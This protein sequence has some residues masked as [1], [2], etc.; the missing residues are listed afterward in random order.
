MRI[1]IKNIE[2]SNFLSF[3]KKPQHISF[4][5]NLYLITG[6]NKSTKRKNFIGKTNLLESIV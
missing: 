3:G 4:S 6:E 2:V 5:N 1:I